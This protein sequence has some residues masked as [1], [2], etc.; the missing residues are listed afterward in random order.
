MLNF[1]YVY[2]AYKVVHPVQPVGLQETLGGRVFRSLC[3]M[4]CTQVLDQEGV[5]ELI[6]IAV[7]RGRAAR[8]DLKIG[9]CGEQ[10]S[11][12][13]TEPVVRVQRL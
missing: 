10:V 9:I 2:S 8:P 13:R 5:G 3:P 12:E 6:K 4:N 7:E 11:H 1:N